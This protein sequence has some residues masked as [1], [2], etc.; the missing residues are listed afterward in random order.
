MLY[1][2][3]VISSLRAINVLLRYKFSRVGTVSK[4][5]L[6]KLVLSKLAQRLNIDSCQ[7]KFPPFCTGVIEFLNNADLTFIPVRFCTGGKHTYIYVHG[8]MGLGCWNK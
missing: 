1:R 6:G 8:H 7:D 2:D 4:L 3:I 5:T